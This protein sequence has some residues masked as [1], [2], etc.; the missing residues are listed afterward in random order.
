MVHRDLADAQAC[1]RDPH[2][3]F[4]VPAIGGLAHAERAQLA[5]PH[6]AKRRHVGEAH[7]VD[8]AHQ[9]AGEMSGDELLRRHAARLARA[10]QPRAHDEV[11]LTARDRR[12]HIGEEARYVAAVAIEKQTIP[13]SG[14]TAAKPDA[15]ARP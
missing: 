1:G 11:R 14:R 4:Q 5:D 2:L 8:E 12:H 6:G 7:A 13:A 15:Q 10:A 9:H 3:H